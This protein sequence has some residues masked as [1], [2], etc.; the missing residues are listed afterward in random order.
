MFEQRQQPVISRKHFFRRLARHA[1]ISLA[2][3]AGSLGMGILGY[4]L[5]EG[6]SWL[7]SLLNASMIL[8]GMGPVGELKT[9]AGKWFA[10][11]Y[12]LF[13]GVAF[14]TTCGVLFAPVV[15]RFLHKFHAEEKLHSE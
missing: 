1:W 4:H 7:D 3:I 12:A 9:D 8:S 6:M 15:H 13:S 11:F 14:I 2:I 10:S 5:T